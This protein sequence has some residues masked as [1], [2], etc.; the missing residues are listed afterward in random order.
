MK[1]GAS[2]PR[3]SREKKMELWKTIPIAPCYQASSLGRIRNAVTGAVMS[4]HKRKDGYRHIGLREGQPKRLWRKVSQLVG[5]AFHGERPFPGAVIAHRDGTRDNDVPN[6]LYWT[7]QKQNHAD[8][9][10][11]GRAPKGT[12]NG[13]AKLSEK[14][15]LRVRE[16]AAKGVRH[17]DIADIFGIASSMVSHIKTRKNWRHL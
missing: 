1:R 10:A 17:S 7:T 13:S 15:V 6:N 3:L 8:R 9:E 5:E 12:R 14:E 11:H 4:P 16:L 2:A